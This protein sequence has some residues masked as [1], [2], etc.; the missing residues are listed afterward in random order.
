MINKAMVDTLSLFEN[1]KYYELKQLLEE[2]LQQS[3]QKEFENY[4]Q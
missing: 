2:G 3:K 4:L 1:G